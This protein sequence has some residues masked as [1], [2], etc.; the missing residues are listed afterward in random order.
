MSE[1]PISEHF[2]SVGNL[3]PELEVVF[4]AKTQAEIFLLNWAP[5]RSGEKSAPKVPSPQPPKSGLT[6]EPPLAGPSSAPAP[7]KRRDVMGTIQL[8]PIRKKKTAAPIEVIELDDRD[9]IQ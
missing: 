3:K 6:H 5:E 4:Q 1:L 8:V 2:L 9:P 7:P